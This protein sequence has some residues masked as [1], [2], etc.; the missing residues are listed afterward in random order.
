MKRCSILLSIRE[1]QSKT[2]I[3]YM[4]QNGKKIKKIK[5]IITP[6]VSKNSEMLD[7]LFIAGG[8]VKG[9]SQSGK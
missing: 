1:I 5:K 2:T 4:D 6:N 3:S 7:H 8:S 9:Y